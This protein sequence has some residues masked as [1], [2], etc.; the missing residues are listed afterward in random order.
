MAFGCGSLAYTSVSE[1]RIRPIT[2]NGKLLDH[3][4]HQERTVW[5]EHFIFG[6]RQRAVVDITLDCNYQQCKA[7]T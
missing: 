5:K 7:A 6:I 2:L 1:K 3:L 4:P